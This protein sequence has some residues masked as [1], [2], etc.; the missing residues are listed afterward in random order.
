MIKDV[1]TKCKKT[2]QDHIYIY[3]YKKIMEGRLFTNKNKQS[4]FKFNERL[5]GVLLSKINSYPIFL[6]YNYE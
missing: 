5:E 4:L 2:L 1:L 6:R 3:Q